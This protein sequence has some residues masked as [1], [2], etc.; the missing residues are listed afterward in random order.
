M[1]RWSF[2]SKSSVV[3]RNFICEQFCQNHFFWPNEVKWFDLNEVSQ[4]QGPK[5]LH[6]QWLN[7]S[8]QQILICYENTPN[9]IIQQHLISWNRTLNFQH[10]NGKKCYLNISIMLMLSLYHYIVTPSWHLDC[11][12]K[13]LNCT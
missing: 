6:K 9:L 11:F 8:T 7:T 5:H 12:R 4:K 2:M 10:F 3:L 1:F 13:P